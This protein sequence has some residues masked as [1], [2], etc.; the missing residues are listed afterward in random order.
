[1]NPIEI[2]LKSCPF[3]GGKAKLHTWREEKRRENPSKIKCT[4][5]GASTGVK[6]RITKAADAWNGRVSD[7]S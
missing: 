2:E 6:K 4:V 3:C 7:G 1:M 5:C